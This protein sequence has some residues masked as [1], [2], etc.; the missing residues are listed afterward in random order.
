M[1]IKQKQ[2]LESYIEKQVRKYLNESDSYEVKNKNTKKI[3]SFIKV[4]D[5]VDFMYNKHFSQ[6]DIFKIKNGKKIKI[7]FETSNLEKFA[8]QLIN[9]VTIPQN[10]KEFAKRKGV[11]SLVKQVASWVEKSGKHIVGGTAIGKNYDTLIL[12]LTYQGAEI[13]IDLDTEIVKLYRQVVDSAKS[14]ATVIKSK[15][16]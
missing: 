12:D 5:V 7:P 13:Y 11:E 1:T 10:I 14:F 3:M 4:D 6:Y 9:E 16:K 8:L 15:E 2:L